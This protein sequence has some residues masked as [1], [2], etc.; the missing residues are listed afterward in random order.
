MSPIRSSRRFVSRRTFV[1]GLPGLTVLPA[2]AGAA[3]TG[4]VTAVAR[5]GE[6]GGE[7]A[8]D[9]H[10]TF[11]SQDPAKVREIV[12]VSHGNYERARVLVEASPA[13]AKSSWDW[14]FGDWESALGAAAHTGNR[15]IAEMLVANGARPNLFSAAMLGQLEV[16]RAFVEAYSGATPIQRLAGPHG[17]PLM[18]HA[19]SGGEASSDVVAYLET[20]GDADDAG[21]NEPLT[22]DQKQAYLGTYRYG[23]AEHQQFEI[24]LARDGMLGL[25]NEGGVMRRIFCVGAHAFHPAGAPAVRIVFEM[26]NGRGQ[27]V[28]VHDPEPIVIA[29]RV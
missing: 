14:G 17:I 20:I 8:P 4:L 1:Q 5:G 22:D 27:V 18:S 19:R 6:E 12:G 29:T 3:A 9:V 7:P 23:P 11:P 24:M 13:L 2:A 15:K 28:T 25:E 10:E 26:R 16:V 21:P